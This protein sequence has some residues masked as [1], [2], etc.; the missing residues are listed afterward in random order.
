MS[1]WAALN[2]HIA[3]AEAEQGHALAQVRWV[4]GRYGE[5]ARRDGPHRDRDDFSEHVTEDLLALVPA[6]TVAMFLGGMRS[7]LRETWF[8]SMRTPSSARERSRICWWR[9]LSSRRPRT[10]SRNAGR[11][12]GAP[13]P[14]AGRA[15]AC[16]ELRPRA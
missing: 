6:R 5:P 8:S 1:S 9:P 12:G 11:P 3:A 15:T 2:Q 7:K 14:T 4:F 10:G 13:A 16:G